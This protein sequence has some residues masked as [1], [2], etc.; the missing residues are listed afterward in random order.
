MDVE[1]IYLDI[2]E[3]GDKQRAAIMGGKCLC[4]Y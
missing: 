3:S 2:A 4:L 1:D